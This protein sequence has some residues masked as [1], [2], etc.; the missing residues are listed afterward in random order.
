MATNT[1]CEDRG[2]QSGVGR[3]DCV[4]AFRPRPDRSVRSG[5]CTGRYNPPQVQAV[6][7]G[8][9]RHPRRLLHEPRFAQ[10]EAARRGALHHLAQRRGGRVTDDRP[11]LRKGRLAPAAKRSP[12]AVARATCR[13]SV[14]ST[15]SASTTCGFSST[16]IRLT[17]RPRSQSRAPAWANAQSRRAAAVPRR[18]RKRARSHPGVP[19]RLHRAASRRASR[20]AL[21]RCEQRGLR[22][23]LCWQG[24]Q[25]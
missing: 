19:S 15:S 8:V 24:P 4:A 9:R 6:R 13:P 20:P 2:G 12:R 22:D 3:G 14:P 23:H 16:S 1:G 11:W 10:R 7:P 21:A 18:T 5:A 25:R 17:R